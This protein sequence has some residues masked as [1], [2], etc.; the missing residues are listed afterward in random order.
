MT[1]QN[2][3]SAGDLELRYEHLGH[4]DTP[5]RRKRREQ[6]HARIE[7]IWAEQDERNRAIRE[8]GYPGIPALQLADGYAH[9][10]PPMN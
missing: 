4:R 5:A 10:R 8:N 9:K 7:E 2:R 3:S 1:R 6:L